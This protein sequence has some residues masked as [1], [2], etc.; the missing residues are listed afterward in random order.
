M[1]LAFDFASRDNREESN[2]CL[3][4]RRVY[5]RSVRR[6]PRQGSLRM[7]RRNRRCTDAK[8]EGSRESS[9]AKTK[10]TVG[11]SR[12]VTGEVMGC[13][14]TETLRG[15]HVASANLTLP[16]GGHCALILEEECPR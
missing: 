14:Q 3:E 16:A 4:P 15:W 10:P 8:I 5:R 1:G 13:F 11:V 9:R 12:R 6:P 7:Y 2:A